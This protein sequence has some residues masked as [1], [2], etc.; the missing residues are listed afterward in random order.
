M[1]KSE[2]QAL[3]S[4]KE[5][6]KVKYENVK[7]SLE[8]QMSLLDT[9]KDSLDSGVVEPITAPYMLAG[10]SGEDWVGKNS[11]DAED[12]RAAIGTA[13]T[14]YEGEI[15]TLRSEIVEAIKEVET[16]VSELQSEINDL[17]VQYAKAPDDE[18]EPADETAY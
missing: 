2:I 13:L 8:D 17:W 3:I 9:Q 10:E 6:E 7:T 12:K 14:S 18:P 16:K 1:T 5:A 15:D 11:N 4:D